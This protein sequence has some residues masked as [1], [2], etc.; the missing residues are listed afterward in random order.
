MTQRI[1][2]DPDPPQAGGSVTICYDFDGLAET[3]A[4]A[5]LTVDFRPDDIGG[6]VSIAPT[7]EDPCVVVQIPASADGGFV[8]DNGGH[9]DTLGFLCG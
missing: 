9:S 7:K 3:V 1:T 5:D 2:I 4:V 6:D 8:V